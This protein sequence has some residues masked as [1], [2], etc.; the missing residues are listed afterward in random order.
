MEL[1][2]PFL[3]IKFPFSVVFGEQSLFNIFD[4]ISNL[5]SNAGGGGEIGKVCS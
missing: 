5:G 4:A 1:E 3:Q 2:L